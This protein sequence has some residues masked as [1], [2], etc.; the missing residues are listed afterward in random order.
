MVLGNYFHEGTI[1]CGVLLPPFGHLLVTEVQSVV[2]FHEGIFCNWALTKDFRVLK[3]QVNQDAGLPHRYFLSWIG[4]S[5]TFT[6]SVFF[7]GIMNS[8]IVTEGIHNGSCCYHYTRIEPRGTLLHQSEFR[9]LHCPTSLKRPQYLWCTSP[10][11]TNMHG[12]GN[13]S[14]VKVTTEAQNARKLEDGNWHL[15]ANHP[16]KK[17]SRLL[18]LLFSKTSSNS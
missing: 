1:A 9:F 18:G 8:G 14:C 11:A 4:L 7:C 16:A 13:I 3:C 10:D 2:V 12:L 15:D 5:T 6:P 17:T